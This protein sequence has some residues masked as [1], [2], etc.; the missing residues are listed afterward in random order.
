MLE[1]FLKTTGSTDKDVLAHLDR[2][3]LQLEEQVT[4][5]GGTVHWAGDANEANQ[6]VAGPLGFRAEHLDLAQGKRN[7]R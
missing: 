2:Y 7:P 4:A 3:L 1:W 6:I 5:R